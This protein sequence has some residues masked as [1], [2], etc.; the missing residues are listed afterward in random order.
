M[1]E[2]IDKL[3]SSQSEI[4]R[5][6][7]KTL[8][9]NGFVTLN[10]AKILKSDIKADPI[11]DIIE[12]SGEVLRFRRYIYVMMNKPP[13][14]VSA[15]SDKNE[16]TVVDLVPETLKRKG[17]F[18]CGRLDKD[19]E[20]LIIISDDGAFAH[21]MLKPHK[22]VYKLYH[23]VL[24]GSIT[25][26]TV[27]AFNK[28]IILAD[29]TALL[30]AELRQVDDTSNTVSVSICE[31]KF[32]QVKKMFLSVG[33]TVLHLTRISIGALQ[34]DPNLAPGECRELTNEEK[35]SIFIGNMH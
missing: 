1:K 29:G 23:A 14:V 11:N 16:R 13:G 20:G 34:L 15:S 21:E 30:P 8:I 7:V 25:Q 5:T 12:I 18:P 6:E 33:L 28:G 22:G 3:I 19:T 4:S 10:G 31:G 17:L 26:E 32:H 27:A 24:D 35:T 2:R 9:K